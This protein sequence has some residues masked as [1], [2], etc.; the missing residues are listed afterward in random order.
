MWTTFFYASSNTDKSWL[1]KYIFLF[2][3]F[4]IIFKIFMKECDKKKIVSDCLFHWILMLKCLLN[5]CSSTNIAFKFLLHAISLSK[6]SLFID[7]LYAYN[8]ILQSFQ[9]C[10]YFRFFCIVYSV[11]C[12]EK[13]SLPFGCWNILICILYMN[14]FAYIFFH[15]MKMREVIN[16][17]SGMF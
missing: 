6:Y 14:R 1:F 2:L 12:Q 17:R 3:L 4:D 5:T 9:P 11:L 13:F 8:A 16:F 7:L 10:I 15:I